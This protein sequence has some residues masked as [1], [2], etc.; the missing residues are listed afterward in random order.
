M[1]SGNHLNLRDGGSTSPI[2]APRLTIDPKSVRE[3]AD[4]VLSDPLFHNSKRSSSMLKFIVDRTLDGQHDLLKERFIG[5]EVFGRTADYD[6]SLDATV[7]V[8]VTEVRKR[9]ALYYTESKHEHELRID[10]PTRSYVAEFRFPEH[11]V[12]EQPAAEPNRP[13]HF[14]KVGVPVVLAILAFAVWGA[15][16]LLSPAPAIEKFW[17]PLLNSPG[18]VSIVVG[19]PPAPAGQ[20]A[21]SAASSEPPAAQPS[22]KTLNAFLGESRFSFST[23]DLN[24]AN[25]AASYLGMHKKES[26]L[27]FAQTTSLSELRGSP[28]IL[29]GGFPNEWAMRL[30]ADLRYSFQQEEESP[31]RGW[32]LGW[33]DDKSNPGNRKWGHDQSLPYTQVTGDYALVN[34]ILDQTTG[35]WLIGICGLTGLSTLGAQQLL[36][37]PKA[38]SA[39]DTRLPKHWEQKN[40]QIVLAFKMVNGS[41]GTAQI[42]AAYSW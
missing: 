37:D 3:Q 41:L 9:L 42:V 13:L 25:A 4:R 19:S 40:V 31:G 30:R 10:I 18:A 12:Q 21:T 33:I 1:A 20:T 17:A 6:T 34:R 8:A 2:S 26:A 39:L 24:A 27:R 28:V 5:M 11:P 38:M 23:T 7:R 15:F 36:T 22:E 29:V 35:Q 16:R 32:G 14:W